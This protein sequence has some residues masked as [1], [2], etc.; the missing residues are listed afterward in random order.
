MWIFCVMYANCCE[1]FFFVIWCMCAYYTSYISN[2]GRMWIILVYSVM[3]CKISVEF[4][5]PPPSIP[6]QLP[7]STSRLIGAAIAT[8]I[9]TAMMQS[10]MQLRTRPFIRPCSS[11]FI[12]GLLAKDWRWCDRLVLRHR[13]RGLP[14]NGWTAL[15]ASGGGGLWRR[16][17]GRGTLP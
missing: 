10:F 9:D 8:A 2:E 13:L 4:L 14:P 1:L 6:L 5:T 11:S 17:L 3:F 12:C 15:A 16:P 7:I